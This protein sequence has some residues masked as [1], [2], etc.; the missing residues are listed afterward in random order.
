MSAA[1]RLGATALA[2]GVIT[3]CA[4]IGSPSGGPE[5][6]APPMLMATVPE[7]TGSYPAWKRDVEFKFDEVISEGGSPSQ[8]F[9]TG[10]LEKLIL[11]S[12]SKGVPVIHWKRDRITVRP[13]EGWKP[14]RVYRIEL[15][16]GLTDLRRNKLD[17]TTVL[18]FSTGGPPPT[19]TLR[20]I[21]I[22]WV[23]GAVARNAV[24]EL[25]LRPDSLVYRAVSDST[26]RFAVGPL[27]HASYLVFAAVD[28]NRNAQRERRES[29]DSALVAPGAA[30]PV[31]WL[32]PRDT[33]GP[34][35]QTVAPADS[36]G[37]RLTMS[38]PID[39]YQS[40][41]SV[42]VTL[43]RQADSS[44]VPVLP[45]RTEQRDDTLQRRAK[46]QADSIRLAADTTVKRDTSKVAPPPPPKQVPPSAGRRPVPKVD[47][48]ADSLL[49]TRPPLT[50]RLMVRTV[51]PLP[52]DT[53][54]IV[55]LQ[56]I[57]S[58]AGVATPST[59]QVLVIPKPPPPPPPDSTARADS[60]GA[61]GGVKGAFPRDSLRL[62]PDSVGAPKALPK[63]ATP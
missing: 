52:P 5:D 49:K 37:A 60:L 44:L 35:I 15:L 25:V 59:R 47:T 1:R 38:G 26:G 57:R 14:N 24:I 21:A 17:T 42:V 29:F 45:L 6:K 8:G 10:D 62:G 23:A 56:G 48:E 46:E 28:Q 7:S 58:A 2:L 3:A 30:V 36:T 11:L 12:P 34:R 43:R 61:T 27:P 33:L 20:G 4:R 31:L 16:P 54:Y 41:D 63:R 13:R 18:T 40:L 19:D 53:K 32:I 50:T 55:E 22:D 51:E 9:G 39:P